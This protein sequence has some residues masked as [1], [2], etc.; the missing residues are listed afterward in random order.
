MNIKNIFM[1][2][3]FWTLLV[4]CCASAAPANLDKIVAVVNSDVITQGELDKKIT[5]ISRQLSNSNVAAPKI[6]VLRQEV[7]D[8]LIDNLLQLQLAKR[9]GIQVSDGELDNIIAGIA[10]NN[11]I[12]V[13]KLKESLPERE[14]MSFNEFRSQIREQVLINRVQQQFLGREI[15]ISEKEVAAV[16]RSSPK[17]DNTQAEYH[18]VDILFETADDI[19]KDKLEKIAKVVKQ[20]AAKLR[21]GISVDKVVD[22]SQSKFDEQIIQNNDLGWRKI[23]ELPELFAK[24]VSKMNV[25]QVVGPLQAPNGMH[26]IKLLSINRASPQSVKIT[27]EQA[28]EIVGH[29][30]LTEKLK[31]LLKEQR[32][33]AY[34]KITK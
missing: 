34:I 12:T 27:V 24:A 5:M 15:N 10:K 30:K 28:R 19:S 29:R 22:E 1:K 4:S 18:V 16:L 23:N 7:L 20:A 14:G 2:F 31:P 11:G 21:R 33:T 9:N 13:A 32:A 25:N 3:I 8:S 17:V 6:S 26:L